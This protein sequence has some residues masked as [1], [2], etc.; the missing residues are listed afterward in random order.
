MY[1]I[2]YSYDPPGGYAN[3]IFVAVYVRGVFICGCMKILPCQHTAS[4]RASKVYA[5]VASYCWMIQYQVRVKYILFLRKKITSTNA[6]NNEST[7]LTNHTIQVVYVEKI[8]LIL[9]SFVAMLIIRVHGLSVE[10]FNLHVPC[11]V[12][13]RLEIIYLSKICEWYNILQ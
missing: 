1:S 13:I 5:L 11:K 9:D 8:S 12:L 6:L 3:K 2:H 7:I 4:F 10:T